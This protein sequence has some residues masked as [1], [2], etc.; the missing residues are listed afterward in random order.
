MNGRKR[1]IYVG[2]LRSGILRRIRG[3]LHGGLPLLFRGLCPFLAVR[4]RE[5]ER[6]IRMSDYVERLIGR[7]WE[8]VFDISFK[9]R[10]DDY[11]RRLRFLLLLPLSDYNIETSVELV[12]VHQPP[13]RL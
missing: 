7:V 2:C 13:P 5:R 10:G 8:W 11:R 3:T 4:V 12:E 6:A 1:G 9:C